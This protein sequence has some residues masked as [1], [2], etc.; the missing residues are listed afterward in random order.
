VRPVSA[1]VRIA[2]KVRLKR[3]VAGAGRAWHEREGLVLTLEDADGVCGIGEAS[4]LS[5][6]SRET[7]GAA[8]RALVGVHARLGEA[9]AHGTGARGAARAVEAMVAPLATSLAD[10]PSARFALETALFD[11]I[12]QRS[13]ASFA[14]CVAGARGPARR[15]DVNALVDLGVPGVEAR[16]EALIA[17]GFR[18]IKVKPGAARAAAEPA[19]AARALLALRARVGDGV[20]L[21]FDAGA[22][23]S[24]EGARAALAAL[25]PARLAFV[26]DPCAAADLAALARADVATPWAIDEPVADPRVAEDV[27]AVR[28]GCVAVVVKPARVGGILAALALAEAA[29]AEGVRVVVTHLFDGPIA[30]SACVALALALEPAPLACGL[31]RHDGLSA[32]PEVAL[33][34]LLHPGCA[35]LAPFAGLGLS[36][37]ARAE[38]TS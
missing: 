19:A 6:V 11:W 2:P 4:P 24:A 34:E 5:G 9:D 14:A 17:S 35:T 3:A 33:P 36:P 32:W 27:L 10:V 16:A 20:E 25:A 30:L 37:D 21:R 1:R 23:W 18:A 31:A 29:R 15:V 26:E 8:A 13:G 28:G 7:L 22:A 12:A 38:L